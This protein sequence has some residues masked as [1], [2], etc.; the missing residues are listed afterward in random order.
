MPS[1]ACCS[2]SRAWPLCCEAAL[3]AHMHSASVAR[4][5]ARLANRNRAHS[6]ALGLDAQEG[7]LIIA[8]PTFVLNLPEYHPEEPARVLS[9]EPPVHA[10]TGGPTDAVHGLA[11][12][13][14][15][16]SLNDTH[17]S[18]DLAETHPSIATG[19]TS[20]VGLVQ[21]YTD[22]PEES[23]KI[24]HRGFVAKCLFPGCEAS[25]RNFDKMMAIENLYLFHQRAFHPEWAIVNTTEG[26]CQVTQVI[27]SSSVALDNND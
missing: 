16:T 1:G 21:P 8:S 25:V 7:G 2:K 9:L 11:A 4:D 19:S 18:M 22:G 26:R 17:S 5:T 12:A 3:E 6:V 10:D 14:A 24:S 20:N 23:A 15:N 27:H 13:M